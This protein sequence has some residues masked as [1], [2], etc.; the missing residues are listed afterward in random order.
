MDQEERGRRSTEGGYQS[1]ERVCAGSS[2]RRVSRGSRCKTF[3]SRQGWVRAEGITERAVT[4]RGDQEGPLA[5]WPTRTR[6]PRVKERRRKCEGK[7]VFMFETKRRGA[8]CPRLPHLGGRQPR[9]G[10]AGL[11]AGTRCLLAVRP[12]I[13]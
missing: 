8:M 12:F 5:A 3:S 2:A 9:S 1:A 11:E 13:N 4:R 10:H 6:S 7:A